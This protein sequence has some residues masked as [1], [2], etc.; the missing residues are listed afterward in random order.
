MNINN[1]FKYELAKE[2]SKECKELNIK[3]NTKTDTNKA[4]EN[5]QDFINK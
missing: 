1:K 2:H 3:N 4:I 5:Y